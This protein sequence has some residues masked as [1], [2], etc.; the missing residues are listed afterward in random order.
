MIIIYR[1]E[2]RVDKVPFI[3]IF[4]E[5]PSLKLIKVSYQI[6]YSTSICISQAEWLMLKDLGANGVPN[7]Q[8]R[9]RS[10]FIVGGGGGGI[11]GNNF[12][13]L[14]HIPIGWSFTTVLL[15]RFQSAFCSKQAGFKQYLL[16]QQQ[17]RWQLNIKIKD[18]SYRENNLLRNEKWGV[19]QNITKFITGVDGCKSSDDVVKCE[20]LLDYYKWHLEILSRFV[21]IHR[22]QAK[23]P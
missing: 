8:L 4:S 20:L 7:S 12:C 17:M 6:Q 13:F 3:R 11:S 23:S 19:F 22:Q 15:G 18:L 1:T 10:L 2:S 14:T 16:E 21:I 5:I 9:D